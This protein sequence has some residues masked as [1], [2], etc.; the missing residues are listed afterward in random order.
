MNS[1]TRSPPTNAGQNRKTL[2]IK[3]PSESTRQFRATA[4]MN[5]GDLAFLGDT[6]AGLSWSN[7]EVME[8]IVDFPVARL[9]Q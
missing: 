5:H 7:T 4:A 6:R 2:L 1:S 8:V 9:T 3:H